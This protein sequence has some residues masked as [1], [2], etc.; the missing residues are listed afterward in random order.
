MIGNVEN[1]FRGRLVCEGLHDGPAGFQ[2]PDTAQS[3][4]GATLVAA[5]RPN[6][7]RRLSAAA[8]VDGK[9]YEAI[10]LERSKVPGF[11]ILLLR[12]A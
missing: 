6:R 9:A 3:A 8:T 12:E 1:G 10:S 5:F 4:A 2:V 11:F 7:G